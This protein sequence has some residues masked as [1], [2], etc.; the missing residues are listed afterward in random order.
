[1]A[2]RPDTCHLL[3]SY[4]E[5]D[6][7]REQGLTWMSRL[8]YTLCLNCITSNTFQNI[9]VARISWDSDEAFQNKLFLCDDSAWLKSKLSQERL[10]CGFCC[11]PNAPKGPE[12]CEIRKLE[13]KSNSKLNGAL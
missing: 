5:R 6:K 13:K 3:P 12:L 11:C 10:T 1:M 8:V 4:T 9:I 7:L 2:A